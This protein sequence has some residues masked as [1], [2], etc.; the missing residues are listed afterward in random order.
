MNLYSIIFHGFHNH[1]FNSLAMS[2]GCHD[3]IIYNDFISSKLV[4][5]VWNKA[6]EKKYQF[7]S[8]A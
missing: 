4:P 1:F 6:G 3:F 5:I 2:Y 8:I 7:I